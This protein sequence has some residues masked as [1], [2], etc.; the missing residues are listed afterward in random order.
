[1]VG[2]FFSGGDHQTSKHNYS[3]TM[4]D[5]ELDVYYV[6]VCIHTFILQFQNWF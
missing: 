1:M 6:Y 2:E 5:S 3:E 4:M